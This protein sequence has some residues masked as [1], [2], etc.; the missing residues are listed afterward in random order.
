ME[1]ITNEGSLPP[2]NKLDP[3][4]IAELALVKD[5]VTLR[6]IIR[7][8]I[9]NSLDA[10]AKTIEIGLSGNGSER[11]VIHDDGCGFSSKETRTI[12]S[13]HYTNKIKSFNDIPITP[14]IGFCGTS[15]ATISCLCNRV[16]I[17]SKSIHEGV[18]FS[19]YYSFSAM[20]GTSDNIPKGLQGTY[21]IIHKLFNSLPD[22][23]ISTLKNIDTI[24]IIYSTLVEYSIQYPQI[25]F[26]L[27]NNKVNV[28]Q[29]LGTTNSE[30][31]LTRIFEKASKDSNSI[32]PLSVDLPNG[33]QATIICGNH[34]AQFMNSQIFTTFLNGR[35]VKIPMLK[36]AILDFFSRLAPLYKPFVVILLKIPADQVPFQYL[37]KT[38]IKLPDDDDLLLAIIERINT[39][40]TSLQ[41]NPD[42]PCFT[43]KE[44][45][46]IYS[47]IISCQRK[48]PFYD[49]I[50]KLNLTPNESSIS[51]L[52]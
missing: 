30:G 28:K 40:F 5:S 43:E 10:G 13:F 34:Q 20:I 25:V 24:S 32:I 1:L 6:S 23:Q 51:S 3:K 15:L 31:L 44:Y 52:C 7:E 49:E 37:L 26:S 18:G 46:D 21:I 17:T 2:V 48:S 47:R 27:W 38:H 11:I 36:S 39:A 12:C 42:I 33:K 29:I 14:F 50:V 16:D 35:R 4:T 9:E 41:Q 45:D 19:A 8:L 22:M